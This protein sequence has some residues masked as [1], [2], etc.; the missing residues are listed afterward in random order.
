VWL[1]G[2]ILL[3]SGITAALLVWKWRAHGL[4]NF[5]SVAAIVVVIAQIG[6]GLQKAA[7]QRSQLATNSSKASVTSTERPDIIYIILDGYGRSDALKRALGFSN[8]S[9]IEGLEQRGFYVAKDARANYCQTE[10]SVA[11]SLNM[12]T[13]QN[14]APP[15]PGEE[16]DRAVLLTLTN[17]S[18]VVSYLRGLGYGF[19]SITSNFPPLQF[20]SADVNLNSTT[21]LS[22]IETALIQMTPINNRIVSHSMFENHRRWTLNSFVALEGLSQPSVAPRFVIAHFLSPHPPFVF[23]PNGEPT[24]NQPPYGFWDGSDYM[25]YVGDQEEYRTGYAGQADF[26]GKRLLST[27]DHLLAKRKT[28]PII[29]IQGDHGSKM[30]LD[31]LELGRTDVNECFPN[32]NAYLVPDSVRKSLYPGITP[33]NSFRMVFNGLFGDALPQLPDKS[34]YSNYPRP[35]DFKEVT[36][37][38]AGPDKMATLPLPT[39][40]PRFP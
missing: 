22:L 27:I 38:I 21:G 39:F 29:I 36:D 26:I 8:Q 37:Q 7:S 6:W 19:A 17:K 2:A 3:I 30:R 40:K 25:E 5:L 32:L 34:W 15:T 1:N 16:Q 23:G 9:F 12:D 11:S 10:L 13:I 31:Q 28:K 18:R 24:K 33:L 20:E 35:F 14:L 4:L